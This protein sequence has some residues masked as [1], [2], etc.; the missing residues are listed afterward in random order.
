MS[1]QRLV[2]MTDRGAVFHERP[3]GRQ[4]QAGAIDAPVLQALAAGVNGDEIRQ[5]DLGRV[6]EVG[7]DLVEVDI[8]RPLERQIHVAHG[9]QRYAQEQ[10]HALVTRLQVGVNDHVRRH[11]VSEGRRHLQHR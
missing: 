6:L 10:L 7:S 3:I 4:G 11:L 8:T 1:G 2:E 9:L 5:P